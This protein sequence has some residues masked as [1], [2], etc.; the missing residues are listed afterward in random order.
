MHAL[1]IEVAETPSFLCSGVVSPEYDFGGH[2]L[3]NLLDMEQMLDMVTFSLIATDA[4]VAVVFAWWG[5]QHAAEKLCG[6]LASIADNDLPD[7]I[8][9]FTFEFFENVAMAPDWWE[10]LSW[11]IQERF[12]LRFL[13]GADP[14]FPRRPDC[15]FPDSIHSVAWTVTSRRCM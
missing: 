2:Q 6:S 4:G 7:A 1:V 15:L 12:A 9:R 10:S 3:Q 14:E 11:D 13:T 5:T 8:A